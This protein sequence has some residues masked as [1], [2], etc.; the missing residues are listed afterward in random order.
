VHYTF[1]IFRVTFS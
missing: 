1:S